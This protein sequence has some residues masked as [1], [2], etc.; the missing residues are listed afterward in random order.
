MLGKRSIVQEIAEGLATGWPIG[1]PVASRLASPIS[2]NH[3]GLEFYWQDWPGWPR[4]RCFGVLGEAGPLFDYFVDCLVGRHRQ[5][6]VGEFVVAC[7]ETFGT[8]CPRAIRRDGDKSKSC[9]K[10]AVFLGFP[11]HV[12]NALALIL[13]VITS[14]RICGCVEIRCSKLVWFCLVVISGRR[15]LKSNEKK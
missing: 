5:A 15:F 3:L 12:S 7:P 4:W 8:V 6:G 1:Q 13:F 14:W 10:G 9:L 11:S 2:F